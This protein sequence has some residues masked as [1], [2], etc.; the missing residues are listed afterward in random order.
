MALGAGDRVSC[1]EKALAKVVV[2]SAG[3]RCE[4]DLKENQAFTPFSVDCKTLMASVNGARC[5]RDGR[6]P[7]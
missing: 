3:Q 2:N 7:R 5:R 4:I 6:P 1:C